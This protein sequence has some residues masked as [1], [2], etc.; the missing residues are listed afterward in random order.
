MR[1][2]S[3]HLDVTREALTRPFS[4]KG[5]AFTEK[6]LAQ[7]TLEADS[8]A[9]AT[10]LGGFSVLWSDARVFLAHSEVGGNI[11]MCAL[12]EEAARLLTETQFTTAVARPDT[13]FAQL[14]PHVHRYAQALTQNPRVRKTFTLNALVSVDLALWKLYAREMG[15][16]SFDELLPL[17]Y[18]HALSR[19]H[20]QVAHIP[21]ISYGVPVHE[22]GSMADAGAFIFK[23]KIGHP[24]TEQEMLQKDIARVSEIHRELAGRGTSRT[25]SGRLLYYLDANGRYRDQRSLMRLLEHADSIGMLDRIV[26][27]EEPFADAAEFDVSSLPVRVAADE[28]IEDIADLGERIDA[29]YGAIALKP[30]GKSLSATLELAA[31]ADKRGVPCFVADSACV[32]ALVEW[33]KNVAAR[34][35]PLPE[36]GLG[37]L[38]SN[39]AHHYRRWPELLAEHPCRGASWIEPRDG[40]FHLGSDFYG[41]CGCIF[42]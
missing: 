22:L 16:T 11:L 9:C 34:I 24:G 23:I 8:G 31:A 41:R 6:W 27:L 33:N 28:S 13:L 12:V 17:E 7:L 3:Y 4:F 42:N 40:V 30:A 19:R 39:G 32:P 29:G 2:V 5:G 36:L 21:L 15:I 37:A 10:G 35:G 18:R 1:V 20:S 25:V 14:V 26:L 38:E